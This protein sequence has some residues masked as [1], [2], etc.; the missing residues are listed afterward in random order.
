MLP[1]TKQSDCWKIKFSHQFPFSPPVHVSV[2]VNVDNRPSCKVIATS[3]T[4]LCICTQE[5]WQN[6]HILHIFINYWTIVILL[7]LPHSRQ[8]FIFTNSPFTVSSIATSQSVSSQLL[9]SK[10]VLFQIFTSQSATSANSPSANRE[11]EPKTCRAGITFKEF[12]ACRTCRT[13]FW[14]MITSLMLL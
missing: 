4:Y 2:T 12:K 7:K 10:P 9:P 3:F 8:W 1:W 14:D 11:L 5:F 6:I 13:P